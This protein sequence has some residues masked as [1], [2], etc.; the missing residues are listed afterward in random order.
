MTGSTGPETGPG[1]WFWTLGSTKPSMPSATNSI[2]TTRRYQ[3]PSNKACSEKLVS[4]VLF[5][6]GFTAIH[7]PLQSSIPACNAPQKKF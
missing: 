4:Q 5:H 2:N 1:I 3:R 7:P 6:F